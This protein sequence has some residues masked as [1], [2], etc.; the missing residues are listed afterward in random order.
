M[1]SVGQKIII[2][3]LLFTLIGCKIDKTTKHNIIFIYTD[4][5]ANH[6]KK[7]LHE[8]MPNVYDQII[9][10]SVEF[11]NYI[12]S[13]PYCSPSRATLLT[14]KY[15]HNH[16]H[17]N[18][19]TSYSD[20]YN[21][22]KENSLGIL[23]QK[24]GY[25]TIFVGKYF[26]PGFPNDVSTSHIPEGWDRFLGMKG[27]KYMGTPF[28]VKNIDNNIGI[29]RTIPLEEHRSWIENSY[30]EKQIE[31]YVSLETDKP[32]F[33]YYAP[34]EPHNPQRGEAKS[35]WFPDSYNS[36]FE[37]HSLKRK[38]I[39]GKIDNNKYRMRLRALNHL[40]DNLIQLFRKLNS[41]NLYD[42]SYI[43]FTSDNG[44]K[45][46]HHGLF[47]KRSPFEAD[48]NVPFYV[49]FPNS[50]YKGSQNDKLIGTIDILPSFLDI[51]NAEELKLDG[52]SMFSKNAR[53]YILSEMIND[54]QT[55]TPNWW[56]LRGKNEK[57]VLYETG[58][59][60][61]YQLNHKTEKLIRKNKVQKNLMLPIL[62][63]MI[64]CNS[65]CN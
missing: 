50:E 36:K 10:E 34:F 20:F 46:N 38:N 57:L 16:K 54:G 53:T 23:M 58:K 3:L 14:G 29:S 13:S 49:K 7:I 45:L 56:A 21:S 18:N 17:Y 25:H 42:D 11:T 60:N 37:N 8:I 27:G 9:K 26:N 65:N 12:C 43:F 59:V 62:R 32:L 63:E 22:Y 24:A 51:A 64:K 5:Q 6:S 39:K 47:G 2:L 19:S 41:N 55:E 40:D 1:I 30:L 15:P 44:F 61:V 28:I 48:I 31:N 52:Q 4:D 35:T 33:I